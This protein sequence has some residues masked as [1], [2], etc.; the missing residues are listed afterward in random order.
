MGIQK[1]SSKNQIVLPKEARQAMRV[2]GMGRE[3]A[4]KGS[5][6]AG[7]AT[8]TRYLEGLGVGEGVVIRDGS[9]LS[10]ENRLTAHGLVSVLRHLESRPWKQVIIDALPVAGRDGTLARRFRD[11]PV[12]DRVRA[13]TGHIEG[14]SGLTGFLDTARG[15]VRFALF[16]Q[17]KASQV[18]AARRWQRAFLEAID[19]G[20]P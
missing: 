8:L 12:R 15:R 3:R 20:L 6:A 16:Y 18:A 1:L 10:R 9:G 14:V 19:A 7:A 2:K 13:K 11:S 4:G 5:F 17:G